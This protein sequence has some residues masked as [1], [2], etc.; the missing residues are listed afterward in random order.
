MAIAIPGTSNVFMSRATYASRSTGGPL[1]GVAQRAKARG[2]AR[3]ETLDQLWR[4]MTRT[5]SFGERALRIRPYRTAATPT[6]E[7]YLG[8]YALA[9]ELVLFSAG[10]TDSVC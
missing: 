4:I 10:L 9:V 3:T 6:L 5:Y 7:R 2:N 1:W 8:I